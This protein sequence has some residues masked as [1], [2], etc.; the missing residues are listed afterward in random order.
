MKTSKHTLS[1][2]QEALVTGPNP[3]ITPHT[4]LLGHSLDC[5]LASL[6]ISHPLVID[7]TVIYKHPR[8]PPFKPSLKWLVQKWLQ[9]QIQGGTNGHDSEEDARACI[10]LLKMKLVHGPEFGDPSSDTESIFERVGRYKPSGG[11]HRSTL[12]ADYGDP[13]SWFGAK[14][15]KVTACTN[16]D[17]ITEAVVDGVATHD[18]V[19]ARLTELSNVQN[20]NGDGEGTDA[21]EGEMLAA[22]E[23]FDSRVQKIHSALPTNSALILL[24]G[25]AD[26]RT[27]LAL[28]KRKAAFDTAYREAVANGTVDSMTTRWSAEDERTLEAAVAEVREGMSFFCVK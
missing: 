2:I 19:F 16:D 25:H 15:T 18:V 7:T 26:P 14:A 27:M 13:R 17:E 1:S 10:D 24:T 21:T 4:I 8:G 9:R 20:W 3:L 28:N 11:V 23:R 6:K 12:V 22:L 5:D